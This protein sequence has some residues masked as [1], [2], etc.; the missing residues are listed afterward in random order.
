MLK[1]KDSKR[2]FIMI[3][4]R[5]QFF[6]T[7]VFIGTVLGFVQWYI[8]RK[9][10]AFLEPLWTVALCVILPLI[11]LATHFSGIDWPIPVARVL[12]NIGGFWLGFFYYSVLVML[13]YFVL[14]LL[15][16]LTG[17]HDAWS[18][19]APKIARVLFAIVVVL[20]AWGG[21]NARH[22]VYRDVAVTTTKNISQ[23][24]K[25]AFVTDIHLGAILGKGYCQDLVTR[26]NAVHP[27]LIIFGGDQIDESL[28][29]VVKEGSYKPLAGLKA[30]LGV[31]A[32]L[33]NHDYFSG[34]TGEEIRLFGE[35]GIK[36]LVNQTA[37]VQN[38]EITGLP[39]YSVD[40][41][42]TQLL[43]EHS[44]KFRIL[45]DHQPRRMQEAST[46]GFDLY[47]AG[48]THAGQLYPNRLITQRM[49]ALDYGNKMFDKLLAIVSDGYG[50]WGVPVR[51][52]PAPE[53]VVITISKAQ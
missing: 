46:K 2:S 14:F 27:D 32:I 13:L 7:I 31:Y 45:V 53:I 4:S 23:P 33:G 5:M 19:L 52:G 16:M 28:N 1:W 17:Q 21:W 47:L 39:D 37:E 42:H 12:A 30:P 3:H 35:E 41:G 20:L 34:P 49:Y 6:L 15:A 24:V 11:F 10:L 44:D 38:L 29:F 22:P 8:Y 43:D 26:I 51:V 36:F 9:G 50:F 40:R 48:H 25:I 18:L